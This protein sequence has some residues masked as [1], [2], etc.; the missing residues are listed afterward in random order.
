MTKTKAQ[1]RAEAVERLKQLDEHNDCEDIVEAMVP[2]GVTV[3]RTNWAVELDTIIDLLTDECG[4]CYSCAKLAE[5]RAEN[6]ALRVIVG[7]LK[8]PTN[9]GEASM[10]SVDAFVKKQ[11]E[12]ESRDTRE[13]LQEEN[14]EL[15][16]A[17]RAPA[18]VRRVP[19]TIG[20]PWTTNCNAITKG[21][22]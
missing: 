16:A 18:D 6:S 2:E 14:A 17:I 8:V 15:R 1:L 9:P 22:K 20:G 4:P 19:W 13:K 5:L 7:D 21:A 3:N 12:H 10:M 11:T